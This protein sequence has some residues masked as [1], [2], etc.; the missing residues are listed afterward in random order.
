MVCLHFLR[1]HAVADRVL[2]LNAE[3]EAWCKAV[4]VINT[5]LPSVVGLDVGQVSLFEVA[6][7]EGDEPP[8]NGEEHPRADET[9]SEGK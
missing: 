5:R 6:V 8:D 2:C 4:N 7:S 1:S 3:Q 9:Q